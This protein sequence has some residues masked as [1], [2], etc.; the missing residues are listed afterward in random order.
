M[1]LSQPGIEPMSPAVEAQSQP[2][3]HQGSKKLL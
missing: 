3:G 1:E 2:L